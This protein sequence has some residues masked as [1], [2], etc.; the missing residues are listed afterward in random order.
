MKIGA[1]VQQIIREATVSAV[2]DEQ[3][4]CRFDLGQLQADVVDKITAE[5]FELKEFSTGSLGT[6][7]PVKV[8]ATND[9]G[10]EVTLTGA[11]LLTVQGTKVDKE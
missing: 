10:D 8:T 1:K 6:R 9:E 3:G 2:L 11:L 7:V 5:P 4:N